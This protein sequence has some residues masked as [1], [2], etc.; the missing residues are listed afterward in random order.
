MVG[1]EFLNF[2]VQFLLLPLL[3]NKTVLWCL[4]D[5]YLRLFIV[6]AE[7]ILNMAYLMKIFVCF[8]FFCLVRGE[9]K[10]R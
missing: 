3:W 6:Y 2:Q 10:S 8:V 9:K 1:D 5:G 7:K 4:A